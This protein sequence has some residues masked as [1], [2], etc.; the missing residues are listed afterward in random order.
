MFTG[1]IGEVGTIERIERRG[2]H[3]KLAIKTHKIATETAVGDSI[4]VNG[5]CLTAVD[6]A[7]NV[8]TFDVSGETL[9]RTALG[10]VARGAR[11][12]IE[13]AMIAGDKL[14]GHFVLGHVDSVGRVVSIKPASGIS[15]GVIEVE[16]APDGMK[17]LIPKGSIA[18]DGV[19]LTIANMHE[20]QFKCV[21][22]EHTWNATNFAEMKCGS[23]VN[24]EY[25][26]LVKSVHR[27]LAGMIECD[28]LSFDKLKD[29]GY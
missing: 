8:L 22:L 29:W 13:T 10:A 23:L 20:Q 3:V 28:G 27:A 12:N 18:L 5:V 11:V 26:Y 25:D 19:S 4:S 2:S 9:E 6:V 15:D 14:A 17:W 21:V 7:G 16:V 1:L 24:I